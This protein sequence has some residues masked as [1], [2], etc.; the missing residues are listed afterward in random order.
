VQRCPFLL[1]WFVI[2]VAASAFQMK[3]EAYIDIPTANFEQG[4]YINA[5]SSY[6]VRDVDDVKFDPN[7]GID[8]T[9]ERFGAALKWYNRNDF[10]L[11]FSYQILTGDGSTTSL[12]VGISEIALNK[13]ISTAGADLTF[14]DEEY[15]LRAPEAWSFYGVIGKKL[16]RLIE[17]NAGLGRG[18]FVGYGPFSKYANTDLFSSEKHEVWAFGL[19][20]GVKFIFSK[21]LAFITE[22]DGRDFNIGLEYQNERIKGTLAFGKLEVLSD[23]ENDFSPRI[24][25]D[26]SCRIMGVQK[27]AHSAPIIYEKN[28]EPV[29]INTAE[30]D[31]IKEKKQI[32]AVDSVKITDNFDDIK[33]RIEDMRVNFVYAKAEL[34]AAASDLLNR[35]LE[36]LNR[37]TDFRLLI[38]GHTCSIGTM[39]SNQILSEERAE[40]VKRYLIENGIPSERISTEALGERRPIADNNTEEGRI[41]NRR[42]EFSLYRTGE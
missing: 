14:N 34:T 32:E 8:F 38:I 12:A 17:I 20:G 28:I 7:I 23:S 10:V 27:K 35:I 5:N 39:E 31:K 26:F 13:Y 24:G 30:A 3:R 22:A 33:A 2:S 11:D 19:F 6:P 18:K 41:K 25:L 16:N 40:S 42:V 21:N 15:T 9:C 29:K 1:F 4:L 36:L 37:Y